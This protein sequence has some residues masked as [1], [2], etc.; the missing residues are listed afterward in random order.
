MFRSRLHAGLSSGHFGDF[1]DGALRRRRRA[2]LLLML[3]LLLLLVDHALDGVVVYQHLHHPDHRQPPLVLGPAVREVRLFLQVLDWPELVAALLDAQQ[4]RAILV[5][6]DDLVAVEVGF[7]FLK[8]S[9]IKIST[10]NVF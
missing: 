8:Q 4:D 5:L 9:T 10:S 7:G 3:L 6:G 1:I 2:L